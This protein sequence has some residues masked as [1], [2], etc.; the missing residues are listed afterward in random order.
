M[1]KQGDGGH[2]REDFDACA[3]MWANPDVVRYIGGKPFTREEVWA[4]LLR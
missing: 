2:R 3:A 1:K 4:R